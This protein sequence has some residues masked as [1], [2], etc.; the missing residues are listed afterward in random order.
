ML[1]IFDCDGVLVDSE[2]IA[3]EELAAMMTDYGHPMSVAACQEAFM[4]R[5]NADIIRGIEARLGRSLPG[6]GPRMRQRMLAR[7]ERELKPVAGAAD[8]LAR[9]DGQR[10]VASSSDH[11]RVAL[12]LRWTGLDRFFDHIFSG[13][14][15]A[16]GKPA[17]DLFRHA[18]A[19]MGV[20]PVDCVVIEDSAM[21]VQA[22]VAAGMRVIGFTGGLHTDAG[23]AERLRAAGAKAI[24]AAMADLPGALRAIV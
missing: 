16:R 24:V 6:E 18:A 19:T 21:G 10:C 13:V 2:L 1:V 11:N 15:V 9:L 4:G 20:A 22:G 23:H 17:P 12:T 5:H 3:L 14:D 7:L 8:V